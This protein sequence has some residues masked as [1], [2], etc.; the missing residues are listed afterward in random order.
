MSD[1]AGIMLAHSWTIQPIITILQ[2]VDCNG[3]FQ[4]GPGPQF[5]PSESD[6][7]L[8]LSYEIKKELHLITINSF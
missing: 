3:Y 1:N 2:G 7:V 8:K 4:V 5:T 6:E